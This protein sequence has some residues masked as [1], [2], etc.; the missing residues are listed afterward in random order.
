V[1]VHGE[2]G[3][4]QPLQAG[5]AAVE[6]E[7]P[8]TATALEMVVMRFAGDLVTRRFARKFDCRKPAFIEQ[9]LYIPIDGSDA[10]A[11]H[12]GLG[13]VEDF[14]SGQGSAGMFECQTNR[15]FLPCVASHHLSS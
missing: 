13:Q 4:G 2:T 14:A 12:V 10:E 5:Q 1:P 9:G 6:F 8:S 3:R 15:G 7:D 11:F